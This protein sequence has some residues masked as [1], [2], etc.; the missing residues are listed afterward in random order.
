M[1]LSDY[2]LQ[3]VIVLTVLALF[4][5]Q[6]VLCKQAASKWLR[7]IPF[8]AP[9]ASL[10][11]AAW[12]ALQPKGGFMDFSM[13]AA[14][15]FVLFALLCLVPI[16]VA[17]VVY[18]VREKKRKREKE[19]NRIDFRNEKASWMGAFFIWKYLQI[20]TNVLS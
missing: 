4:V 14:L 20:K 7:A 8:L 17:R 12:F 9:L 3:I 13:L 1:D 15:L 6:Y 10:A 16:L 11:F 18:R 5:L 2:T 19:K